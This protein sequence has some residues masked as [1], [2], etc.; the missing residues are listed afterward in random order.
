MTEEMKSRAMRVAELAWL[1]EGRAGI[2][3]LR[4]GDPLTFVTVCAELFPDAVRK[5]MLE[6]WASMSEEQREEMRCHS[7]DCM[8]KARH[9][10]SHNRSLDPPPSVRMSTK[11]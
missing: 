5:D 10:R 4:K 9:P 1:S 2:E 8:K 11:S 3:R 7:R 6:H